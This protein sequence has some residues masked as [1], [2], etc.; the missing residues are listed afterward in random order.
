MASSV[1]GE[2]GY[3]AS[4]GWFVQILFGRYRSPGNLT[5]THLAILC[6]TLVVML[7]V[8]LHFLRRKFHS[9]STAIARLPRQS[10][11]IGAKQMGRRMYAMLIGEMVRVDLLLDVNLRPEVNARVECG[12][13]GWGSEGGTVDSVHFSTSVAKSYFV[14][15]KTALSRRP[16]LRHRDARTIRDYVGAL[17]AAF[18]SLKAPLC[19]D[20]IYAYERA[21]FGRH[22]GSYEEYTHFIKL[23]LQMVAI[24][25]GSDVG[26]FRHNALTGV[27]R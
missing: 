14:L 24:I 13:P 10:L 12:D 4:P 21:V 7:Y 22:K 6:A 1:S 2:D 11:S 8:Y 18:P 5:T 16:G 26:T 20:Y 17:R 9:Y 25:N 19:D 27:A 3:V 23:V 15:E